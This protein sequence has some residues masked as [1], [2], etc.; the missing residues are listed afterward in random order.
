MDDITEPFANPSAAAMMIF[1]DP[2][3][4]FWGLYK[5]AKPLLAQKTAAKIQFL[6]THSGDGPALGLLKQHFD[7]ELSQWTLR[8]CRRDYTARRSAAVAAAAAAPL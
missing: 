6:D 3:K 8:Q 4:M 7:E 5:M 2:P 1:V